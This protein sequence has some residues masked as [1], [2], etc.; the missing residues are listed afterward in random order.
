MK[1]DYCSQ[2]ISWFY[3]PVWS[4]R[5]VEF[6]AAEMKRLTDQEDNHFTPFIGLTTEPGLRRSAKRI[7]RE[8]DV[9]LKYG[10][11]SLV[12]CTLQGPR[13]EPDIAD[14]IR[15][16]LVHGTDFALDAP[17]GA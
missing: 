14:A 3:R 7:G 11:G 12:F 8:L 4:L 1:L 5:R 16:R 13:Q 17:A 10:E 15:S 2:T 6:E 9:A